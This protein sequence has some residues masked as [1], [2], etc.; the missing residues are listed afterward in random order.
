[1]EVRTDQIS[2]SPTFS[3]IGVGCG[4]ARGQ[5]AESRPTVSDAVGQG[6]TGEIADRPPRDAITAGGAEVPGPPLITSGPDSVLPE[7]SDGIRLVH[8]VR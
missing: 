4:L 2:G 7:S 8:L 1:M 5:V 3:P 6:G